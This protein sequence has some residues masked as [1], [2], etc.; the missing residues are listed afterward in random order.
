MSK[1]ANIMQ[2]NN[3]NDDWPAGSPLNVEGLVGEGLTLGPAYMEG[4]DAVVDVQMPG[5]KI[6]VPLNRCHPVWLNAR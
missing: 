2:M 3:W 6:T 4:D 5:T 1:G